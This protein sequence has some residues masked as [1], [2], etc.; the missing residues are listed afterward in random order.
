VTDEPNECPVDGCDN[1]RQTNQ[2]MCKKHWYMVPRELRNEVWAAAKKM[3]RDLEDEDAY[4]GWRE[5][6]D[7]AIGEVEL[8]E[9][10][11]A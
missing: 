7:T 6:A 10:E 8:K 3:W 9:K 4:Q 2:L 1:G 11:A 5:A